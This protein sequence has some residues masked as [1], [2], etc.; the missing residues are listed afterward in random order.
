LDASQSLK[1]LGA[2]NQFAI[3]GSFDMATATDLA[4]D[5]LS[6]LGLKSADADVNLKNLTRVT[7]VLVSAN[8]LANATTEQFST[9]LTTQAGPAMKAYNIQLEEGVAVLAAYADQGIKGHMAG[10]M[11]SRM[12]RLMTK[13]FIENRKQWQALGVNIFDANGELQPLSQTVNELTAA[14]E[15]MSTEQ[16]KITLEMLGF[17]ARSEQAILPLLGL[18]NA[19]ADYEKKLNSAGG[20]TARVAKE[21]MSS[22]SAQM[23]IFW[24]QIKRVAIL[25]GKTLAPELVKITTWFNANQEVI[26]RWAIRISL[27]V[28]RVFQM[29]K[30]FAVYMK[31]DFTG[32]F[33]LGLDLT[34]ILVKTYA[35]IWIQ[36]ISDALDQIIKLIQQK[37]GKITTTITSLSPVGFAANIIKMDR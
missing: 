1:S 35:K 8:T 24:N 15:N 5:A 18:G 33:E 10:S 23:K 17:K 9:A 6:A 16:K 4:T 27:Q 7:D 3:A 28:V 12:L 21:N 25:I 34:V 14:M 31:T 29:F 2:V 13:G 11:F 19:I 36:V 20:T 32:A 22:F 37:F 26:T 30:A